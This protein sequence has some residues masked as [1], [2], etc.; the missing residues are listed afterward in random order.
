LV[1]ALFIVVY[2]I[3]VMNVYYNNWFF[4]KIATIT[5][6]YYLMTMIKTCSKF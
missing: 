5:G 3:Y 6:Y 2:W 1:T 4:S